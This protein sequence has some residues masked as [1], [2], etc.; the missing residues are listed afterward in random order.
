MTWLKIWYPT[1]VLTLK[2]ITL[3]Q[4]EVTSSKIKQIQDQSAKID[5]PFNTKM[6]AK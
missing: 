1:Y 2:S 3:L 6:A 5:I 4:V